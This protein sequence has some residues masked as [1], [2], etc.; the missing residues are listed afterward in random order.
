MLF[1]SLQQSFAY[2]KIYDAL[3]GLRREFKF[4]Q[5]LLKTLISRLLIV[6]K[7]LTWECPMKLLQSNFCSLGLLWALGTRYIVTPFQ[8]C[9]I[10]KFSEQKPGI[11][12]DGVFPA[13][14][15]KLSLLVWQW[16]GNGCYLTGSQGQ[17]LTCCC[18]VVSVCLMS[19]LYRGVSKAFG[20]EIPFLSLMNSLRMRNWRHLPRI[21]YIKRNLNLD[22][23]LHLIPDY[24]IEGRVA[25]GAVQILRKALLPPGLGS[26][27]RGAWG[28]AFAFPLT[29]RKERVIIFS[30]LSDL[31]HTLWINCFFWSTY[32]SHYLAGLGCRWGNL[33]HESDCGRPPSFH[34]RWHTGLCWDFKCLA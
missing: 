11:T 18:T 21:M 32:I 10:F 16:A 33:I 12:L 14:P 17:P 26:I 27:P 31:G 7:S 3:G 1:C 6:V 34:F 25:S 22:H 15:V 29:R 9:A 20:R 28:A 30:F 4:F 5:L 23:M 13:N 8:L 24:R 2:W 19:S